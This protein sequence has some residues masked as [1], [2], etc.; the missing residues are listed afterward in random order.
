[1]RLLVVALVLSVG[2]AITAS[3][4]A[5]WASVADAPWEQEASA[6]VVEDTTDEI[7][8]EGALDL[9]EAVIDAGTRGSNSSGR[10]SR[11]EFDKQM[12]KAEREIARYC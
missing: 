3:V 4:M 11:N 5:T 12:D 1:M 2:V 7:R 8:C 9:R 6:P 10:L